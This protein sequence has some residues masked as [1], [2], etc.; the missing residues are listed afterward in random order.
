MISR[1]M[2]VNG[3]YGIHLETACEILE[4]ATNVDCVLFAKKGDGE[5]LQMKSPIMMVALG[6]KRGDDVEFSV[7]GEE[8]TSMRVLSEIS[9]IV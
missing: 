7:L 6:A 8:H 9:R 5:K 4:I 1:V 2:R 3:D